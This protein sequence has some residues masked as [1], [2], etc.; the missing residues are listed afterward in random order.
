MTYKL[1]ATD[2]TGGGLFAS[3][4]AGNMKLMCVH[5]CI[6]TLLNFDSKI[7]CIIV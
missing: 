4:I 2:D 3:V 1:P 5:M 7:W 6:L